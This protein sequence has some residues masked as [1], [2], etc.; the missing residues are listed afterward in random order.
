MAQTRKYAIQCPKCG[1]PQEVDLY[2]SVNVQTDVSLREAVMT[3]SLNAVECSGCGFAFRVEK[4]LLYHDPGRKLMIYWIPAA[5][6]NREQGQGEFQ[7]TMARMTSMIPDNLDLPSIHLVFS[8]TELVERI[9]TCEAGLNPR[10]IEYMKYML[11][12]RNMEKYPPAS[13]IL[14][15]NAE[16]STTDQLCFVVQNAETSQYDSVISYKREA[17]TALAEMFDRDDQTATLLELFPGPYVSARALL[18]QEAR[19]PDGE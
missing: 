12:L 14:L 16:D 3:N 17:Y 4:A 7:D 1:H 19:V 8:R 6:E 2:E 15:F 5:M 13:C 10:I 9:F 11:Y 18:L